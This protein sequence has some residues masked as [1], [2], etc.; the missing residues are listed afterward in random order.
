MKGKTPM[1]GVGPTTVNHHIRAAKDL[2]GWASRPSRRQKYGIAV[3][4][5]QEIK[6]L[7]EKPRER[8]ITDEEFGH[9]LAQCKDGNVSG[10]AVDFRET[11]TVLRYTT[12]RPGEL[13]KLQWDFIQWDKNRIV[14]PADMVKNRR[15]REVTMIDRVK[16]VLLARRER[17]EQKGGKA[18]G[19][20]FPA[21]GK[22]ARGKRAAVAA[23][24]DQKANSL[25]QRFRR[26]VNLCVALGLIEK[27]KA[28]E[29]IV[30][31]LTRHTRITEL[32]VE[33]LDH[34]VV[35]HDAGHV[36]PTTTERYKHLA[37]SHVAEQI[38]RREQQHPLT[39]GGG[40]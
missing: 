15:R 27:E 39:D 3:N 38:R 2:F 25:S 33:G 32:F 21:V 40:G 36:I 29:R 14:Y 6:S 7:T 9:L 13:R 26:L 30:C 10:G 22:D 35:M 18:A 12:M 5:W 31:Y 8:L 23:D 34:A 24:R 1:N 17:I 16:D 19:R 37:G 11:L 4:P 28:G 20:V